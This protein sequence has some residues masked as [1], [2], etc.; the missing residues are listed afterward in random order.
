VGRELGQ[1]TLG[2]ARSSGFA[3][4]Q[5]NAVVETNSAAVHLWQS[6]GYEIVGTVPESF[7]HP[8]HGLVGLHVMFRRI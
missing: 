7:D 5:F 4:I 6:L 3:A 2:W 8:E 1:Y